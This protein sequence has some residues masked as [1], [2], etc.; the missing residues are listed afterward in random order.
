VHWSDRRTLRAVLCAVALVTITGV[1]VLV[2][3]RLDE[4]H[5]VLAYLLLVLLCSAMA[6]RA[7]GVVLAIAC[8]ACFN[9]FLLPP[10]HTLAVADPRDW[11]VLAAFLIT[12]MI[13][14]QLLHRAQ[15]AAADADARADEIRSL[16]MLGA[17]TLTAGRADQAV[18]AIARVIQSTL[19][20]GACEIYVVETSGTS[21]RLTGRSVRPG[22]ELEPDE[23]VYDMFDYLVE[24]GVAIVR[25]A[26]D[27]LHILLGSDGAL[28]VSAFAQTDARM[29]AVPLRAHTKTV[30]V[31]RLTNSQPI[32]LD[33]GQQRF[34]QALAYYAALGVERVRY[35]MEAER[36]LAAAAADRAKDAVI[37][38]VSHDLRTPLTTIKALAHELGVN[39]G[40]NALAIES[41]ADRLNRLVADLLD[42]S[43]L[44]AGEQQPD[45]QLNIADDLLG[46]ALERIAGLPRA[47]DVIAQLPPGEMLAGRFDFVHSL[48]ALVN[49][50][51]NALKYS[52]AG[53][54]VHVTAARDGDTLVFSVMDQGSGVDA[55][56]AERLFEPFIRGVRGD[57]AP[58]GAGLGLAIA[59]RLAQVQG[60]SIVYTARPEGGSVFS[61]RLPAAPLIDV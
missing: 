21:F 35:T 3:D 48:R 53:S 25:R 28:D 47:P 13:A 4:A 10:Y 7:V 9:F 54:T 37:A 6:G 50:I 33:P 27:A 19:N 15:R 56:D 20:V 42:L 31:L 18:E 8:F 39:G 46:A 34:A 26:D 5:V 24:R 60:G 32:V 41:E 23:R 57:S 1:L 2:R 40:E 30:G 36:A 14:T 45:V 59:Q 49:L 58:E 38:A 11:L 55:A 17:E 61:L 44:N 12:S 43:R 16:S 22:F 29:V 51:E 52:P